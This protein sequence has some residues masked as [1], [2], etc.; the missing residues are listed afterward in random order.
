MWQDTRYA[1]R[2]LHRN[3]AFATVAILTV[4]LGIGVATTTFAVIRSTTFVGLVLVMACTNVTCLVLARTAMREREMAVRV[5]LG[6][7]RLRLVRQLIAESMTLVIA[8][9]VPGVVVAMWGVDLMQSLVEPLAAV[10]T[11]GINGAVLVFC[12]AAT[13][14]TGA[15]GATLA[16]ACYF[17]ASRK[18]TASRPGLFRD[19][20]AAAGS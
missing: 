4:A 20:S 17:L 7:A 10:E 14:L 16:S 12:A 13:L 18:P 2:G 19:R 8:A 3:P 6:A 1:V 11:I 5:A 9:A 15:I